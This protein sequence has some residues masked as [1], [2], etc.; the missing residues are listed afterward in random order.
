M[1]DLF[2]LWGIA[3][4]SKQMLEIVVGL[5]VFAACGD[6]TWKVLK[7]DLSVGE[8]I[9]ILNGYYVGAVNADEA[10]GRKLSLYLLH[11]Y[12]RHDIRFIFPIYIYIIAHR[13]NHTYIL[14]VD[15]HILI[16]GL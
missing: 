1:S 6:G 8:P 12:L 13:L 7:M 4:R 5:Q 9:N 11:R 2:L 16:I 10:V 15:Y 14:K 3:V